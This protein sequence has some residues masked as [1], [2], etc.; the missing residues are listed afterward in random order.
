MSKSNQQIEILFEA[1]LDLETNEERASFLA[2]ECPDSDLRREVEALLENFQTP[3]RIFSKWSDTVETSSEENIG[4][5]ID[6]Y[7]LL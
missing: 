6:R 4:S 1:A 2:Q 7:R 5:V 3:D